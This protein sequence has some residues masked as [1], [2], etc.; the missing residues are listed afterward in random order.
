MYF[1]ADVSL[2]LLNYADKLSPISGEC[3]YNQ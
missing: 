1:L 3:S 2:N